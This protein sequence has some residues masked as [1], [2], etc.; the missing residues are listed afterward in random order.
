VKQPKLHSLVES[1][2][3]I[4]VGFV[5]SLLGQ[6]FIFPAVG[7]Q[8]NLT[9][10]LGVAVLFTILSAARHYTLRRIFTRHRAREIR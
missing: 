5:V 2:A 7:I 8:A 3:N 10:N 1:F 6:L 4:A 9:Q